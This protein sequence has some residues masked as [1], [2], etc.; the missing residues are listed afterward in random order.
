MKTKEAV[1][2][3]NYLLSK[4]RKKR[5]SKLNNRNVTHADMENAKD[6]NL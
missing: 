1:K 2:L 3:G 4:E 6:F 5:I